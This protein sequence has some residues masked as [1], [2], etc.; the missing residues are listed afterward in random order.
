MSFAKIKGVLTSRIGRSVS[1]GPPG[2]V[3]AKG[4]AAIR[5]IIIEDVWADPE[6]N[7]A[8]RH[9]QPCG[10]HCWGDYSFARSLSEYSPTSRVQ[11]EQNRYIMFY[12]KRLPD[13][14]S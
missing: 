8:P 3:H 2:D 13:L 5:G 11:T 1:F 12:A 7:S 4:G 6:V 9:P 14:P 10:E